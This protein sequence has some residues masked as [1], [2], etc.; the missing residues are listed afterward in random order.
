MKKTVTVTRTTTLEI[1][2]DDSLLTP[3]NLQDV[4]SWLYPM[5]DAGEAFSHI[6]KR[7]VDAELCAPFIEGFGIAEPHYANHSE[8]VNAKIVYREISE[9]YETEEEA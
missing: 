5:K 1:E 2:V 9:N 4:S 8:L 7:L 6:A 3:E